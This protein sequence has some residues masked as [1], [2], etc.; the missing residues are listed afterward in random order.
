MEL[1]QVRLPC[2]SRRAGQPVPLAIGLVVIVCLSVFLQM[3]GVPAPLLNAGES[4]DVGE[5]SISEGFSLLT[6]CPHCVVFSRR[7]R[8]ADSNPSLHVPILAASLFHP[9]LI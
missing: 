2:S 1:N 5:A 4:L 3:L 7:E 9:P 8:V 6:S